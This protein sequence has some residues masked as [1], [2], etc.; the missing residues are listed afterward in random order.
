[1]QPLPILNRISPK[2]ELLL[3]NYKLNGPNAESFAHALKSLVPNSLK[4]L[5]LM[6][7]SLTDNDVALM[8]EA[9]GNIKISQ[10]QHQE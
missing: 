2:G 6:D 9:L 7:N 5:F 4:K 8:F 1:V 10:T 3:I